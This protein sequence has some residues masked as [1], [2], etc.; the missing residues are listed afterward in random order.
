MNITLISLLTIII[1]G[2][3]LE[4]LLRRKLGIKYGY[5]TVNN[6]HK[7]GELVILS[8][9][10]IV[11]VILSAKEFK[12]WTFFNLFIFFFLTLFTFRIFMEWKYQKENKEYI[13]SLF[14][15]SYSMII[16][17]FFKI[18]MYN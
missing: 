18:F 4:W 7:W 1:L 5:K 9:Y 3:F 6:F 16:I 11:A 13:I 2:N 12:F 15:L 8:L 10:L 14:G 17:L